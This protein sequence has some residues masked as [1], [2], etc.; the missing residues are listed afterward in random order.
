MFGFGYR[1]TRQWQ[2]STRETAES[3][4]KNLLTVVAAALERDMKGAQ[5]RI[6]LPFNRA[7]LNTSLPYD[8]ADRFAGGFARYPY[9]ESFFVWTNQ[10]TE[11]GST[12]FFN[13]ADRP[14]AWD[15]SSSSGGLYPVLLRRDPASTKS[16]I[17]AARVQASRGA[18]F[19][20]LANS[21][22]ADRYQ[23]VVHLLYA[24][25][26]GIRLYAAVGFTVNLDWVR[27]QYFSNFIR[28]IQEITSERTLSIAIVDEQGQVV[29][30]TGLAS[31][32]PVSSRKFPLLFADPVVVSTGGSLERPTEWVVRVSLGDDAA[33]AAAGRGTVRTIGL[34]AVA[35]GIAIF[36]LVLAVRAARAAAE[37]A[38]LQAEFVSAVS[39]EMKTPLALIKLASDTLATGRYDSPKTIRDYG[40]LPQPERPGAAQAWLADLGS[41]QRRSR[42]GHGHHRVRKCAESPPATRCAPPD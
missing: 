10:E 8:L 29:A 32:G 16:L 36:A 17:A 28:E 19:I 4:A 42:T 18:R 39:H 22:G 20:T 12:Y 5:A 21:I 26:V 3:R 37:L 38:T 31:E 27:R 11:D 40:E 15:Q 34:L 9:L 23:T 13:R 6:L 35:A 30:T 25:D 14:P 7:I 33:L 41:R 2:R 24:G 1:A